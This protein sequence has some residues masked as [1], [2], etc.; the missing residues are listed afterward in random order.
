MDLAGPSNR[1]A[2]GLMEHN[3]EKRG[4]IKALRSRRLL[5][6]SAMNVGCFRRDLLSYPQVQLVSL[7]DQGK[8][9]SEP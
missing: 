2:Q 5:A 9:A 8:S 4:S 3:Q 1:E 6:F 7:F